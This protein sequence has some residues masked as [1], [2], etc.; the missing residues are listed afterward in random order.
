MSYCLDAI[1]I[2]FTLMVAGAVAVLAMMVVAVATLF[3]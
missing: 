3:K 2:T 1:T